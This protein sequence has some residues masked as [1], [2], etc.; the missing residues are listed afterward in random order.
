M[1]LVGVAGS[2]H[3]WE[4]VVERGV[5]PLV[6]FPV[7]TG[8]DSKIAT[9]WKHSVLADGLALPFRS[10]SFDFVVSNAVIEHVGQKE[11]QARFVAEHARVGRRWII[12][13]PNRYFPIESHTS[14]ILKHWSASWRHRQ[15]V[16]TRLV[17]RDEFRAL[18]P[19]GSRVR[20]TRLGP[21]FLAV[22]PDL[23]TPAVGS[24]A[25]V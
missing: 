12:T 23:G 10:Q 24:K 9:Q 18:L 20:G 13:T 6:E 19:P 8:L 3:P 1:L 14:V 22:S 4:N 5:A 15:S 2:S 7:I 17:S 16:F 21:T 11:Q 25:P